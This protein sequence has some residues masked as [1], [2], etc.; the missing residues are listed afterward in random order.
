[1]SQLLAPGTTAPDFRLRVTP[2]QDLSLGELRGRR[3]ILS[4]L[5]G[6]LE[7]S[8]RRPDDALQ[9]S[10]SRI[11]EL[12]CRDYRHFVDGAWCH[13]AYAKHNHIHFPATR[14]LP[15]QRGCRA[16]VC[17]YREQDGCVN[18]PLRDRSEGMIFWSYLSPI[19]V[20]PGAMA[21]SMPGKLAGS[22]ENSDVALRV[23][24]TPA[25]MSRPR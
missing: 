25:T 2:D 5:P 10:P 24:S 18:A 15:P 13:Q 7:P 8:L 19:A 12:R 4:F 1:M 22:G 16:E 14:R 23:P 11:S 20:N 6:G 21:S 3:V 17:A 9:P